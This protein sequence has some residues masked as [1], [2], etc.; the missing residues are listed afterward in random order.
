MMMAGVEDRRGKTVVFRAKDVDGS[1]GMPKILQWDT[2]HL[3][4]NPWGAV[5][6]ALRKRCKVAKREGREPLPGLWKSGFAGFCCISHTSTRFVG[7]PTQQNRR[8]RPFQG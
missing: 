7:Q 5:R 2:A 3:D 1:L 4:G 6:C 8:G